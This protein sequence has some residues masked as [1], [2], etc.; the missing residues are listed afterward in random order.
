MTE[1]LDFRKWLKEHRITRS[2][3]SVI[4]GV[5]RGALRNYEENG[6]TRL[7]EIFLLTM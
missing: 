7:R 4:S 2:D 1:K 3:F 6:S 5:S